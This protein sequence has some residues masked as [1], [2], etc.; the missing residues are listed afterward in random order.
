MEKICTKCK[1]LKNVIEFF[2]DKTCKNGIGSICKECQ[3]E[4]S[5]IYHQSNK[6]EINLYH[7][8]HFQT[9]KKEQWERGK[10]WAKNNPEKI[11]KINQKHNQTEKHKNT[12]N[13][14]K[15]KNKE[16][17]KI[18]ARNYKR[19]QLQDPL[20]RIKANLRSRIYSA[21]I[22]GSKSK[23][24]LELLGCSPKEYKTYLELKF[25]P[26]M[27]W[28]NYGLI[29]EI[30]HIIPCDSFDLTKSEEQVKCFNY[31]N[32][33]PLLVSENRSKFNKLLF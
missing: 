20:E 17:L 9:H 15:E 5:K 7:K 14:W 18:K 23:K 4:Y 21:I 19:K 27:T 11:K 6:K 28:N 25:T 31:L 30:D 32:T 2:K 22:K 24:S 10:N 12:I 3:R 16:I 13:V 8:E 26:L 29:W 33:Q 1:K